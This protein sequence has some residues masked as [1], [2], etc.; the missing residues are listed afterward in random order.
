LLSVTTNGKQCGPQVA[1]VPS[2]RCTS[3]AGGGELGAGLLGGLVARCDVD[4]RGAADVDAGRVDD[5]CVDDGD[6]DRLRCAEV[7]AVGDGVRVLVAG[8]DVL[9]CPVT[10]P[11]G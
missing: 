6:A 4:G 2:V 8:T 1:S 11:G 5:G 3:G 10:R 7:D 9:G